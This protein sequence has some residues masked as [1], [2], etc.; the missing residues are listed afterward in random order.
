MLCWVFV[1]QHVYR[2]DEV[3]LLAGDEVV[4]TNAGQHTDGLDRFFARLYG[5]PVPGL[6]FFTLSVVSTQQRRAFPI[7]IEQIVRR[8]AEK[9]ASKANADAKKQTPATVKRRPGRPQ[10]RKKTPKADVPLTPEL[11]RITGLLDALL[12]R[13]AGFL[14]LT[15][16]LLD[17][18]FGNHNA[19]QMARH[20]HLPLISKLRGDAALYL[21]YTGPSAGRGPH[22]Q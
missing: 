19:R 2:P 3:S 8:A 18:H 9:A 21:P 17:G 7:R 15:Y 22:R 10:G 4:V 14:P 12:T 6:A 11:W 5:K 20:S 1:R 13:I 16:V